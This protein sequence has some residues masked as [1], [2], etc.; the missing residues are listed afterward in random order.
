[1]AARNK[2][3]NKERQE[4]C[5]TD[6]KKAAIRPKFAVGLCHGGLETAAIFGKF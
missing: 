6:E 2:F 5:G 4:W 1:M 3:L